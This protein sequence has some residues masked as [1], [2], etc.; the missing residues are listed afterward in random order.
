MINVSKIPAVDILP[1]IRDISGKADFIMLVLHD[2]EIK[3]NN[4]G[5]I[6]IPSR[7]KRSKCLYLQQSDLKLLNEITQFIC[8]V[9][10]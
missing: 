7:S 1:I 2:G 8:E 9:S 4:P 10:E 5:D 3:L 6:A